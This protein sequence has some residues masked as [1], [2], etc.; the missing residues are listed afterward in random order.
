MV[1]Y[2]LSSSIITFEYRLLCNRTSA[3]LKYK[4]F[5][6]ENSMDPEIFCN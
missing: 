1:S 4:T 2:S 5:H 3:E 6:I